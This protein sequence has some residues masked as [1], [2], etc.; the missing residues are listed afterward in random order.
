MKAKVYID[1]R[2]PRHS[3]AI[4]EDNKVT[5][6]FGH[7]PKSYVGWGISWDPAEE[8]PHLMAQLE[9]AVLLGEVEVSN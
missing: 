2:A 6:C 9:S 3:F 5:F 7:D 8:Y 4:R 1:A